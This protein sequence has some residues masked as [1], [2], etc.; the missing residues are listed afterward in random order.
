LTLTTQ[1]IFH[2]RVA[3]HYLKVFVQQMRRKY[4]TL[5][6]VWRMEYQSR[7]APH[8][9]L[10]L[11]NA[12]WMDK[13]MIQSEWGLVVGQQRP[14]TR[15][16]R[17]KSYRQ[18][19]A[20]AG[21][22][23]A[24]Q[25]S[26]ISGFNSDAYS[27]TPVISGLDLSSPGRVWGVIGR[28]NL[29]MAELVDADIPNDDSWWLIRRYCQNMYEWIPDDYET[30]FTVFCDDPYHALKHIVGIQRAFERAARGG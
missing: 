12:P 11:Y 13:E 29:P 21:K 4:P 7:G 28:D 3:K 22:Y 19:M 17:V 5:A 16:E 2:P 6:V 23:V 15:I 27:H 30:G 9:H 1:A 18:L 8:F 20:Y 14:F 24:K 10:I 25:A 26:G